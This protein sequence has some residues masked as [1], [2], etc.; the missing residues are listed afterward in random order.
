MCLFYSRLCYPWT[1]LFY[2]RLCYPWTCLFY[3][4]LCYPWT[5]LFYSRLCYSL[6]LP[7]LRQPMLPGRVCYAAIYA[8]PG[9]LCS[10]TTCPGPERVCYIANYSVPL[11]PVLPQ[12][13]SILYWHWT[14]LLYSNRGCPWT[15]PLD[16]SLHL[17][18][19]RCLA[20]SSLYAAQGRVSVYRSCAAPVRV[21]LC[22]T[23]TRLCLQEAVLHL[24]VCF[25]ADPGGCLSTR[26]YAASVLV[27]LCFCVCHHVSMLHLCF[28]V[29]PGFVCLQ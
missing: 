3:S 28:C 6:N 12:D 5:C 14:C 24:F 18:P 27:L 26:A 8:A 1:C 11:Q 21:L 10:P 13:M 16:R 17:H 15:R 19:R 9:R 7:V 20:Y 29:A 25:C 2:C 23:R 22:C 4:R